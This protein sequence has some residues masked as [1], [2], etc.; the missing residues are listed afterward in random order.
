MYMVGT[1]SNTVTRSRSMA[2]RTAAAENLGTSDIA[3]P[4]S[5]QMFMM[6]DRP[7]TWSS[8]SAATTTTP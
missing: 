7:N 3:A 8:G 2:S 6:L 4:R 5:T 1:P